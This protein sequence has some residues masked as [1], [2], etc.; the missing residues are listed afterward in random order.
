M[1]D[2]EDFKES[3]FEIKGL[4]E[5]NEELKDKIK[6]LEKRIEKMQDAGYEIYRM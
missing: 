3:M 6:D 5:E 2:V 4:K 1:P